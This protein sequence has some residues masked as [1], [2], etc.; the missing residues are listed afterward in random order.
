MEPEIV[1]NYL[2][3]VKALNAKWLLLRNMRE[4]KQLRKDN[5]FGVD[6]PIFSKDYIK[7]L[8]G[9]ELIGTNVYKSMNKLL[10]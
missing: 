6:K 8:G 7:M 9:Y 2:Q 5:R 4:G 10:N 1:E 3:K